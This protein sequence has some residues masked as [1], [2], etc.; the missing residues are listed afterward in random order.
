[1]IIADFVHAMERKD[2]IAMSKCFAD[3]SRLFDYCPSGFG[4]DTFHI[5]G[6]RAVEMFYHNKFILGGMSVLDPWIENERTA[7][8]YISYGGIVIHATATIEQYDPKSGLIREM[9][10]R[11]A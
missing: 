6:A 1:M 7:N 9:V 3:N 11:P 2:Y 5:F 10:I 8:L 4:K